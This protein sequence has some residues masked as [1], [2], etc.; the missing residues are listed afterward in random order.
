[1]ALEKKYIAVDLGAE[2]GRVMLGRVSADSIYLEEVHR[3]SN[4]PIEENGSLRWNFEKLFSEIKTGLAKAIKQS[5]AEISGIGVDSWGVDYGL[6]DGKGSLIENPYHYRDSRTS[7]M[8]E[9]SFEF[10]PKRKIYENTGL[11]F[12]LFN[13]LYQLLA[14]RL[15]NALWPTSCHIICAADSMRNIHWQAPRS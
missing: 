13:T 6:L 4:G 11:Q 5:D 1:M 10:M 8:I 12:M 2:S 9:K 15:A 7:G 3:F 14:A